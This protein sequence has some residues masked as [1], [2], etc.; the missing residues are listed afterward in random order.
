MSDCLSDSIDCVCD[1]WFGFCVS[2]CDDTSDCPSGFECFGEMGFC[3]PEE[4]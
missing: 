4:L 1:T 2:A 3:I